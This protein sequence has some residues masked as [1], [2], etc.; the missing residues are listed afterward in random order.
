MATWT[1]ERRV[2]A[3]RLLTSGATRQ[4]VADALGLDR[5]SVCW[6]A[7]RFGLGRAPDPKLQPRGRPKTYRKRLDDWEAM[8]TERWTDRRRA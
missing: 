6:A 5:G 1:P 8:L 4:A 7:A 3:E 2:E